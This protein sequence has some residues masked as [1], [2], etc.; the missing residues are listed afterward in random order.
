MRELF[1]MDLKDYDPDGKAVV[2]PSVRGIVI[3][4]K[5]LAMVYS[6]KFDYYKFPG[7]GIEAGETWLDAL[8][9]EV[10]EE[11]GLR[12]YPESVR[13]FGSVRRVMKGWRE[14]IF[15][16]DNY[17]YICHTEDKIYP[18]QLD[19]YEAEER[20]LLRYVSPEEAIWVNRYHDHGTKRQSM[21]EREARVMERL[22]AEH[23]I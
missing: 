15:I 5:K 4:D 20:F 21:L 9:R 16:Q 6:Q 3:K 7:G 23:E 19:N 2:R 17:Y 14:D 22:M 13:E 11:A 10:M 12:V 8:C 18:Q 1:Y